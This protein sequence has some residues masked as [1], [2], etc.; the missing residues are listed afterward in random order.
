M[1]QHTHAIQQLQQ[2]GQYAGKWLIVAGAGRYNRGTWDYLLSRSVAY[3]IAREM[4]QAG[5][6]VRVTHND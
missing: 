3:R 4:R 6:T 2:S 5:Y 1:R